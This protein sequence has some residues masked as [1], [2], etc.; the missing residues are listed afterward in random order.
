MAMK[1]AMARTKTEPVAMAAMRPGLNGEMGLVKR[2]CSP[3]TMLVVEGCVD[4]GIVVEEVAT[5]EV[6]VV[7]GVVDDVDNEL[8][9]DIEDCAVEDGVAVILVTVLGG[10]SDATG[11]GSLPVLPN[12]SGMACRLR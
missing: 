9:E 10:G 1:M 2:S 8:G 12:R 6:V 7:M 11:A 4:V 3:G 5:E